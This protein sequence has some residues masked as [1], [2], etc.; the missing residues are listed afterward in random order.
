M[1]GQL[2]ELQDRVTIVTGAAHGIGKAAALLFA[3]EGARLMLADLDGEG[4][5]AVAADLR[6][7]GREAHAMRTD[8]TSR[9]QV[10]ALIDATIDIF[11]DL[12]CAFNNAGG[13]HKP[14]P[15]LAISD[16]IWDRQLSLNLTSI[17]YCMQAQLPIMVK[18]GGGT[19]VNT[20]S[21]A[22]LA[23]AP[24]MAGYC[25]AKHGLIGL[26]KTAAAEF[27]AKNIRI[28]LIC[29]TATA[30]EGMIDYITSSAADPARFNG[31]MGRMGQP[32]E[33]AEVALWLLSD[34]ASYV[35]GQAIVANG[36]SGGQTA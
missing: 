11:G 2:G 22:G 29:P 13:G 33:Q 12:H 25:A 36:G 20:A 1:I 4:A 30:T 21:L 3:K 15:L 34:R 10:N 24:M 18:R 23:G 16:D 28:N 8:V 26:S 14:T 7:L 32:A 19:I 6:G 31:P 9:T 35:T 27:V 5:E 17:L